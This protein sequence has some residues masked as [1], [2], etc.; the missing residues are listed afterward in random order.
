MCMVLMHI[1]V[2]SLLHIGSE[3][4]RA[5]NIVV[6]LEVYISVSSVF[7]Y[8]SWHRYIDI[9]VL[10]VPFEGKAAIILSIPVRCVFIV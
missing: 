3:H 4:G 1:V 10:I 5:G 6:K 2:C 9:P 7:L 8:V